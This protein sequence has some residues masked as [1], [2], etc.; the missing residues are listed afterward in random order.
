MPRRR[1][2]EITARTPVARRFIDIEQRGSIVCRSRLFSP[3]TRS[4]PMADKTA[5]L[6]IDGVAKPIDLPRLE[7]YRR[8]RRHRHRAALRRRLVYLRSRVSSRPRRANRRSRTSTATQ[9]YCCIAAIRSN[10]SRK[11]SDHLEVCYLLLN[12]ELPNCRTEGRLRAHDHASHDGARTTAATCSAAFVATRI[13][14]RSCA[15][16][17]A[18]WP[19]SITTRSTSIIPSIAR[20][21]HTA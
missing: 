9:A 11:S 3:A 19:R 8:P 12:G 2:N 21:P 17:R 15:A 5:R 7:R 10:N 1:D 14:W 16:S 6:S 20:S 18:R 4:H 13:R